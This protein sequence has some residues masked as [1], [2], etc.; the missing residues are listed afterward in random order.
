[1][2]I[3]LRKMETAIKQIFTCKMCQ[4]QRWESDISREDTNFLHILLV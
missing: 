4:K 1:M 3:D 2:V